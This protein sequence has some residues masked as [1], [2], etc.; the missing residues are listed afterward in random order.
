MTSQPKLAL[1]KEPGE[2]FEEL[3]TGTLQKLG[4]RVL[5]A[6]RS[7]LVDLLS[8]F[9]VTDRLYTQTE[10][11]TRQEEP[12]ALLT[13]SAMEASAPHE[14]R[15]IFRHIG[16]VSLYTA[17]FFQDSFSRKL[18][19]VDYYI[20]MGGNA[21]QNVAA[22]IAVKPERTMF[23][24]L[25]DRFTTCVD[26]L[27]EI[28]AQTAQKTEKDLLRMYDLWIKTHSDRAARTLREAGII[29]DRTLKKK[30]Q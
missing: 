13:M 14:Q 26:I 11:G 25:A 28:S 2:F 4:V 24:E 30:L 23:T 1:V 10:N 7:Y 18:V 12:L 16:D 19:D 21:Y 22:R 5:P 17:G 3:I 8:Q 27:A 29:P 9:M 6:T 20:G 15:A